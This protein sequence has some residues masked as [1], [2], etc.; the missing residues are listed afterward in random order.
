MKLIPYVRIYFERSTGR[1]TIDRGPGTARIEIA[2]VRMTGTFHTEHGPDEERPRF[3]L[4]AKRCFV[5]VLGDVAYVQ[6]TGE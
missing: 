6:T 1:A 2:E 3:W 4:A 5:Q